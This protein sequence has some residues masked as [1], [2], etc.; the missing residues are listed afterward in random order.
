MCP[1]TRWQARGPHTS[2]GYLR[3]ERHG[4]IVALSGYFSDQ[5]FGSIFQQLLFDGIAAHK[6]TRQTH[7]MSTGLPGSTTP[8]AAGVLVLGRGWKALHVLG[9]CLNTVAKA[10]SPVS[11][12][13]PHRVPCLRDCGPFCPL[14]LQPPPRKVLLGPPEGPH[15]EHPTPQRRQ[16]GEHAH[17]VTCTRN[18]GP[19]LLPRTLLYTM[20]PS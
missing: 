3:Q 5:V 10:T 1:V 15:T 6:P 13:L 16:P 17:T 2:D 4:I 14:P 20:L 12:P 18:G 11:S 8:R 19:R 7:T 9:A